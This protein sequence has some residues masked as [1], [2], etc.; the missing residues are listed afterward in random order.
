MH[1]IPNCLTIFAKEK[2]S[3]SKKRCGDINDSIAHVRSLLGLNANNFLQ[4]CF[5]SFNI[6]FTQRRSEYIWWNIKYHM[7]QNVSFSPPSHQSFYSV[8]EYFCIKQINIRVR[9]HKEKQLCVM[10]DIP[11]LKSSVLKRPTVVAILSWIM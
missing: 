9:N 11:V 2:I 7:F 3:F 4:Q 5:C 6:Y 10:L 8:F 1:Q